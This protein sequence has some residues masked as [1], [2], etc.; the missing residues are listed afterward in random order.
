MAKRKSLRERFNK[1][2][3]KDGTNGCW[4]WTG[5]LDTKGYG[6]ISVGG[7][8]ATASRVGYTEFRGP[9]PE[10]QVL[11]HYRYPEGGCIG[12]RC[13]NPFHLL[14][15]TRSE[16]ASRNSW[17]RKTRCPNG[18][19]YDAENTAME[20][21]RNDRLARRCK[22]CKRA[23]AKKLYEAKKAAKKVAKKAPGSVRPTGKVSRSA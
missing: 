15:T 7:K 11:D 8:L 6:R 12:P 1:K 2:V 5:C 17:K 13:V 19:P 16:N 18:H 20:K 22:T 4:V 14:A 3:K 9:I 10:G 21:T 23:K